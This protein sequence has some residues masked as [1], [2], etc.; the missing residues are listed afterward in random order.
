MKNKV[1]SLLLVLFVALVLVGCANNNKEENVTYTNPSISESDSVVYSG[2]YNNRNF[3]VTK[4]EVYDQVKYFGGLSLLLEEIDSKLLEAKVS[5]ITT[6]D[7]FYTNR[8]NKMVYETSNQA[9]IDSL[10]DQEKNK[11]LENY[12]KTLALMGL[13]ATGAENYIKLLAAR[14]KVTY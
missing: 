6:T 9:E 5:E 2:S 14:D 10:S 4:G 8:Y 13:D 11:L 3:S 7:S 1:L 12:N